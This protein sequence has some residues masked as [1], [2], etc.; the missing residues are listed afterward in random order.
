MILGKI[1][2]ISIIVFID[3]RP[4]TFNHVSLKIG[5][6]SG[7]SLFIFYFGPGSKLSADQNFLDNPQALGEGVK[8]FP[9][10][11]CMHGL[12]C[13]NAHDKLNDYNW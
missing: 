7:P 11:A 9:V 5:L 8:R 2:A 6:G 3:L 12:H 10:H 4:I 13:F 1:I